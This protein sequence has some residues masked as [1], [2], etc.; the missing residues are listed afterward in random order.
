[1]LNQSD[2]MA[3]MIIEEMGFGDLQ[4][5][6]RLRQGAVEIVEEKIGPDS[7][8]ANKSITD[9]GL[10]AGCNIVALVRGTDVIV[11]TGS[12]ILHADDEIVVMLH[13][14]RRAALVKILA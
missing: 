3:T 13:A 11:P 5:L 6:V 2:L 4:T 14:D 10:P 1:M 9:L 8:A 12:T 7:S